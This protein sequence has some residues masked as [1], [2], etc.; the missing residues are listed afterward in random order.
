[1]M[2]ARRR[3]FYCKAVLPHPSARCRVCGW[4][5]RYPRTTQQKRELA[6]GVSLIVAAVVV[7]VAF[8][9]AIGYVMPL[10]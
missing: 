10:T 2:M 1:M 5:D 9:I 8:A 7:A 6:A 3:C 4:A